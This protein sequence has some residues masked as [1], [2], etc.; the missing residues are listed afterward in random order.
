MVSLVRERKKHARVGT[1]PTDNVLEVRF[2][3]PERRFENDHPEIGILYHLSP[4]RLEMQRSHSI[5]ARPRH[6]FEPVRVFET[7]DF[8]PD[9]LRTRWR[10]K[11]DVCSSLAGKLVAQ[12]VTT[13]TPIV[14][15]VSL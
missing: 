3:V 2:M 14:R 6:L 13:R 7:A 4:W 15:R 8:D 5:C 10:S 1:E 12:C 11:R 9:A